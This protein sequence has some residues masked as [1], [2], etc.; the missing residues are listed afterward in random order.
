MLDELMTKYGQVT[1]NVVYLGTKG[2]YNTSSGLKIA[3]SSVISNEDDSL[4]TVSDVDILLTNIW[5]SQIQ[6]QSKTWK[7]DAGALDERVMGLVSN[8][9]PRY[10][11]AAGEFFWER[12]PFKHVGVKYV[13]RFI[14]L[15]D[16]GAKSKERVT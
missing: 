6:N 14:G 12:E 2:V 7:F 8:I 3:Y 15:G 11:F 5:P 13:G 16:V 10:H 4:N 1:E 9:K